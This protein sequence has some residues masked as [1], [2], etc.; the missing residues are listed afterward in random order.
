MVDRIRPPARPADLEA[1]W[2][3]AEPLD[4]SRLPDYYASCDVFAAP[5]PRDHGVASVYLEAMSCARP[6]VAS[7]AGGAP[8]AVVDGET[9]FLVAP[10]DRA[11]LIDRLDALLTSPELRRRLGQNGRTRVLD[12][13]SADRVAERALSVYEQVVAECAPEW[14][15]HHG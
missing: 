15:R 9:G 14:G 2:F 10:G 5:A 8:E 3:E 11:A 4:P 1:L 12:L 6:V 13:F 7:T